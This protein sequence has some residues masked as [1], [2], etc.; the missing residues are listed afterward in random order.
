[1]TS[2]DTK[3]TALVGT[4][5]EEEVVLSLG[6]LCRAS[7][8]SAERVIELVHAG[9]VE[10]TGRSPD[11]WRFHGVSLQRIRCARRLRQ[12]LDVNWAGAALALDLL[13]EIH[14]LRARLDRFE[15]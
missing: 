5:L 7:Q 13:D 11:S 2:R 1:M 8:L 15:S 14:R 4:I 9:V 6:E 3:S 10:P 12:D